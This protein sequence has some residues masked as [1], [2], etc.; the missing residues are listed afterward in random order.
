M[1]T[2]TLL[3]TL[4]LAIPAMAH[5]YPEMIPLEEAT[6]VGRSAP[7]VDLSTISGEHFSLEGARGEV[8]VLSFWASWCGPCRNELP[9]LKALQAELS[10]EPVRIVLVNV[11]KDSRDAKRFLSQ[12]GISSQEMVVAMDHD[13][14]ALGSYGVMSMPTLFLIDGN[15]TVKLRKVGYSTEKGLAELTAAIEEVL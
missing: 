13:A 11:D 7:P 15:G 10:D 6:L 5:A 4:G 14:I 8:V 9:A 3:L 1:K 12:I 2:T